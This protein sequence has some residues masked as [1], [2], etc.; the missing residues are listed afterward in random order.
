MLPHAA[1]KRP[2]TAKP[3]T[4]PMR[5]Y[6]MDLLAVVPYYT[7]H[8]SS[9]L[10]DR[11]DVRLKVG[12]ITYHFDRE[13]FSRQN[14]RLHPGLNVVSK[15]D[16]KPA[17]LRKA[18]KLVEYLLNLSGLLGRICVERPEILHVQFLPLLLWGAPV[19][20]WFL[21]AAKLLGIRIVYTV[22]NLLPQG[23]GDRHR[24][25]YRTVYGLADALICHDQVAKERLAIDF[26]VPSRRVKVIPHG[27]LFTPDG[28]ISAREARQELGISDDQVFIL[29]LGILRPYKGV[30]FLLKAWQQV[31]RQ[32]AA[33]RLAVVG[34]AE[35]A[36]ARAVVEEVR[37]LAMERSVRLDFRFVPEREITLLY[38]AAD[39]LVYPYSEITTSGALMTGLGY[40]KAI[41]TTRLEAFQS[42]LTDGRDALMVEYGDVNGLAESL[43]TLTRDPALRQQL[44]AA[45]SKTR[46]QWQD[47]P[48][49]AASTSELYRTVAGA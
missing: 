25:I 45:A 34:T 37:M 24:S 13:Y 23:T 35:P 47:W 33:A 44:A 15:F 20:L 11:E 41:V 29:W 28:E 30:S 31:Q 8:L 48:E 40:E 4:R 10:N 3:S 21:R 22:H 36:A 39:I 43:L 38:S 1:D 6:M 42:V 26:G 18:L 5:V 2:S 27:P 14:F 49:I 17:A 46:A 9:A 19:E 32:S 16:I 12:A 7:G